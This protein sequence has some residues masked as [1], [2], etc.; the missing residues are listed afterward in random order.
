M[1]AAALSMPV[2]RVP[3]RMEPM[4]PAV[5]RRVSSTRDTTIAIRR[6]DSE[7]L[8][9]HYEAW[10]GPC[11]TMARKFTR[12]DESFCLDIVQD[13]MLR[14]VKA[15][16][17]L[18]TEAQ[19][20]VWMGAVVRTTAIDLLRRERRRVARERRT[21]IDRP[22]GEPADADVHTREAAQWLAREVRDLSHQDQ[23]LLRLRFASD[24]TL[25]EVAMA[26]GLTDGMVHGRIRRALGALRRAGGEE[27]HEA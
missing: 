26:S 17:I 25:R 4:N 2:R 5:Q 7:A 13:V 27:F 6:G 8:R 18:E 24:R 15:M 10:F 21:H 9:R 19:M 1:T 23:A 3:V 20:Q 14:I 16:P 12:R 22:D 11:Y